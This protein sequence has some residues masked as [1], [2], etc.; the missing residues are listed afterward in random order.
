[1]QTFYIT[2]P[3]YYINAQPHIGHS[4]TSIIADILAR[5]QRFQGNRV[6]FLT[7]T[8]EHG[9]KIQR[10]AEEKGQSPQEFADN[11]VDSFKEMGRVLNI[12]NDDFIRTTE[13]RHKKTVQKLFTLIQNNN[14][15]YKGIYTGLYCVP[16]ESFWSKTQLN[17]K[18][19]CPDCGRE[20]EE[21]SE[22]TYFFRLSKY[23]PLV[24]EHI[25]KNPSFCQPEWKRNE[26]LTRL[27][28][29]VND[30]SVS[31]TTFTWGIPVPND[32]EHVIYVWF[33]A[34]INYLSG[35]DYFD[36][37]SPKKAFWPASMH[38]IGK[39]IAWFHAVIWPAMLM[40]AGV[41]LPKKVFSHGWLTIGGEKMSKSLGN[42]IDPFDISQRFTTDALRYYL[43][44]QINFGSDGDYSEEKLAEKF[45]ADLAHCIG[46]LLNRTVS[47]VAKYFDSALPAVTIED[48]E[49]R[50][51]LQLRDN[52]SSRVEKSYES[53]SL[54]NISTSVIE[55]ADACNGF[56]VRKEPWK[57]AKS[58]DTEHL[59]QIMLTLLLTLAE[60][61]LNLYP[62][63]PRGAQKM[64][65]I[66]G[67]EDVL[68]ESSMADLQKKYASN[69]EWK[70]ISGTI[71]FPR[72]EL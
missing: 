32:P 7:G 2:T 40:S 9:Q 44:S 58:G 48:E 10:A 39:E 50:Q 71:P 70:V 59:H 46:N 57:V 33:D 19:F 66:L 64:W 53:L 29:G 30:L 22:E 12:T 60:I 25:E 28:E 13:E 65:N 3:I 23:A 62:L 15:I 34:L 56:I 61:T 63:V 49:C 42:S 20:V 27:K 67:L 37:K 11:I 72:L 68:S 45:N 52:L 21:L 24:Q 41:P 31:R 69:P 54:H 5:Y 1:M 43:S 35:I 47:M 16:C 55:L 18:K 51:L 14:D 4:Y 8:D 38:L 26:I 17:E 36:E 6:F